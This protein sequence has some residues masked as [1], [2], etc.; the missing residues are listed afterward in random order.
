MGANKEATMRPSTT[1]PTEASDEVRNAID[2]FPTKC[3]PTIVED[4]FFR[5]LMDKD[6]MR[7]VVLLALKS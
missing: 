7:I 4:G 3:L 6:F 2:H 1:T 5:K